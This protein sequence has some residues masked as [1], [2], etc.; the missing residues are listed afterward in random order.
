MPL[1]Y[2]RSVNCIALECGHHRDPSPYEVHLDVLRPRFCFLRPGMFPG[3]IR[4]MSSLHRR[5]SPAFHVWFDALGDCLHSR[6]VVDLFLSL[7]SGFQLSTA[8]NLISVLAE[9]CMYT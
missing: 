1:D 5:S 4:S 3:F 6:C 8:V 2:L 9:M 7:P